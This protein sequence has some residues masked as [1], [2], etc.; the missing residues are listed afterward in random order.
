VNTDCLTSL[1]IR[2][3]LIVIF[4]LVVSFL[5]EDVS[6]RLLLIQGHHRVRGPTGPD[7]LRYPGLYDVIKPDHDAEDDL[8]PL[9]L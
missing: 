7:A 6:C 5:V 2:N 4:R 8:E 3:G 9:D 1:D